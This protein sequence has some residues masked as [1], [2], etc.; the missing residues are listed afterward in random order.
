MVQ[1]ATT[2]KPIHEI[3]REVGIANAPYF[4]TLFKKLTGSTP[5]NYRKRH[6]GIEGGR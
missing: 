4:A 6:S 1:L 3:G 5:A 2:G